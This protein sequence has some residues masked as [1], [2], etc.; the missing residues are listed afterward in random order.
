MTDDDLSTQEIINQ[1]G[2]LPGLRACLVITPEGVISSGQNSA[3]EEIEHFIANAP[4]SHEYLSGLAQSI[5]IE[6]A[7][8]FTLRSG[9]TVRTFFIERGL[10]LAVLHG[11]PGFE[12]GV[13]DK[14]VVT[15]RSL[16]DLL[17]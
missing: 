1:C 5:G 10:C 4:R 14:L 8:S 17:E 9:T 15:L 7:G 3:N 11:Q 6:G 13:R 2:S 16:A 12:P